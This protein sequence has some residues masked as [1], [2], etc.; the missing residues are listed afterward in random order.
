MEEPPTLVAFTWNSLLLKYSVVFYV[1]ISI[2]IICYWLLAPQNTGVASGE[3]KMKKL[4]Q[5]LREMPEA[6]TTQI[7]VKLEK[8]EKLLNDSF[9]PEIVSGWDI[10]QRLQQIL[11]HRLAWQ[12]WQRQYHSDQDRLAAW[13]AGMFLLQSNRIKRTPEVDKCLAELEND[14]L[15][16]LTAQRG[17][18]SQLSHEKRVREIITRVT[19]RTLKHLDIIWQ[20]LPAST[21]VK[22]AWEALIRSYENLPEPEKKA[23]ARPHRHA[24]QLALYNQRFLKY[25]DTFTGLMQ[26]RQY[27]K[28]QNDLEHFWRLINSMEDIDPHSPLLL[29][30]RQKLKETQSVKTLFS[31]ANEGAKSYVGLPR[32]L[33]SR[34]GK[35]VAGKIEK[36]ALGVFSVRSEQKQLQQIALRDLRAQEIVFLAVSFQKNKYFIYQYAG[37][38]YF[39]EQEYQ[40]ARQAFLNALQYGA[41]PAEIKNYL[42]QLP[43][44]TPKRR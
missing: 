11:E 30:L 20:Q 42:K 27:Q 33:T 10:K 6:T 32:V 43:A 35:A 29:R 28:A 40:H 26:Q 7:A 12:Q 17:E 3:V 39:Y 5:Q 37:I 2:S 25:L 14:V 4:W 31:I 41:N 22:K 1:F 9:R 8:T 23:Q 34:S 24:R 36:Y 13:F 21:E 38:F 15:G 16:F 18:L 44:T 19:P